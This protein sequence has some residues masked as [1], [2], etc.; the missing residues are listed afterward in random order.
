[1]IDEDG[2]IFWSYCSP[3]AVN[4]GAD[5]MLEALENLKEKRQ[6]HGE[7]EDSRRAS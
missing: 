3:I 1:V 5:G 6:S 4:P 7:L 2:V